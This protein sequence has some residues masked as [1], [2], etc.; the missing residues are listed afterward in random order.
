MKTQLLGEDLSGVLVI[1]LS[2]HEGKNSLSRDM[3]ESLEQILESAKYDQNLKTV[4]I[5][6]EVSI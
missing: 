2:R 6:S 3:V 4:I 5:R 1:G